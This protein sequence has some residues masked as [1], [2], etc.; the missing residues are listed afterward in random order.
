[1]EQN[2]LSLRKVSSKIGIILLLTLIITFAVQFLISILVNL[3]DPSIA[4]QPWY[5]WSMTVV[6]LYI[7]A[8]PIYVLMMKSI[9]SYEVSAQTEA[10]LKKYSVKEIIMIIFIC[11]AATYIFNIISVALNLLIGKLKGSP[12]TNP[13]EVAIGSSSVIYTFIVACVMAPIVEEIMFRKLMLNKLMV[14]DKRLAIIVTSFAFALFHGNL[15]QLLYAFV[16]G[17]IFAHIT[18]KSGTV[19]YA[20]ILHIIIN[21]IGSIILPSLAT[22]SNQIIVV[23]AGLIVIFCVIMGLILFARKRKLLF[24][25]LNESTEL[26]AYGNIRVSTSLLSAGMIVFWVGSAILILVQVFL[27]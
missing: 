24:P 18:I 12:V 14:Y 4:F 21:T 16:L 6:S 17:V 26:E 27:A 13:L 25:S 1:M 20:I 22:S 2:Q 7:I 19:K 11:L 8:F 9:P 15:Y 23:L 10:P 3:L 5:M